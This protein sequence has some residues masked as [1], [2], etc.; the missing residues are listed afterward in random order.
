M[1]NN[2]DHRPITIYKVSAPCGSGKSF[3]L[4]NEIEGYPLGQPGS[5]NILI[6]LP[7]VSLIREQERELGNYN[8]IDSDS[9]HFE[10]SDDE[11]VAARIADYLEHAP[12][13]GEVLFISW[14]SFRYIDYFPKRKNWIVYIDEI[15]PIDDF[16]Y[17]DLP[18]NPE[19][20]TNILT[21]DE[22]D[23]PEGLAKLV[24]IDPEGFQ[25]I[26]RKGIHRDSAYGE[27]ANL[28][29]QVASDN[30]DVF[31]KLADWQ[32][33]YGNREKNYRVSVLSLV[34]PEL[35]N[36][37]TIIGANFEDSLL[38]HYFNS[39]FN[40]DF[41]P[42]R[43]ILARLRP[44]ID[45]SERVKAIYLTGV[46]QWSKNYMQKEVQTGKTVKSVIDEQL[47]NRLGNYPFLLC[48]NVEKT[49]KDKWKCEGLP[50]CERMPTII[51]GVNNY[52]AYQIVVYLPA[53]NRNNEH[54]AMLGQFGITP[55][56]ILIATG[57]ENL[58]QTVMRTALRKREGKVIIICPTKNEVQ[59]LANT[60]KCDIP[61]R[62]IDSKKSEIVYQGN[63]LDLD[64]YTTQGN[65]HFAIIEKIKD[66]GFVEKKRKLLIDM[67]LS[68]SDWKRN[69]D[70]FEDLLRASGIEVVEVA[71]SKS[72]NRKKNYTFYVWDNDK[73]ENEIVMPNCLND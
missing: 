54:I 67:G 57:Y 37:T 29:K 19:V 49:K 7:T 32:K 14:E 18:D 66:V 9:I 26:I 31:V 47:C 4:R 51:K 59:F 60:L 21:T 71:L 25:T 68:E 63:P 17:I 38:Y 3:T 72:R 45:Y 46:K 27:Y 62:K 6:V 23:C 22:N 53:L 65:Q 42:A 50:R 5:K 56:Q 15:P 11:S 33:L 41:R 34:R 36:F 28:L 35:F 52:D 1:Y 24:P 20:L 2:T 69:I 16:R 40:V 13:Y 55:E 30:F 8:Y 48:A 39:N 64:I 70:K 73:F 12:D 43:F 10:N 44:P 58:Y 61:A